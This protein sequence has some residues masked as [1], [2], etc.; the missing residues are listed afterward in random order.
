MSNTTKGILI[1]VIGFG[2][3]FFFQVSANTP[4]DVTYLVEGSSNEFNITYSNSDG[5]TEQ[6]QSVKSGWTY[7]KNFKPGS[8][9]YIS[10]QNQKDNGDVRVTIWINEKLIKESKSSGRYVIATASTRL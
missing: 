1:A 7:R 5:G 4:T 2:I 9:L 8:H 3:Y 6:I 10:A